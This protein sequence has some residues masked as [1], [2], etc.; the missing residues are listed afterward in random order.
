MCQGQDPSY[1]TPG[2]IWLLVCAST[3]TWGA[4][5]SLQG[6]MR[7]V[8]IASHQMAVD[9]PLS[10]ALRDLGSA[11]PTGP[12]FRLSACPTPVL[13]LTFQALHKVSLAIAVS[14][15][16]GDSPGEA[17]RFIHTSGGLQAW[18]MLW[19]RQD[20]GQ[21]IQSLRA[22]QN[23]EQQLCHICMPC[24]QIQ[25]R[26]SF[27]CPLTRPYKSAG[28]HKTGFKCT[29]WEARDLASTGNT[30]SPYPYHQNGDCNSPPARALG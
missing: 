2:P 22:F 9:T 30:I 1:T 24:T 12:V 26:Y 21:C 13:L 11:W 17:R 27:L 3:P 23:L 20:Y 25:H 5:E 6:S 28:E 4:P 29:Y 18:K 19:T 15:H 8:Y 10:Q 7:C 14:R 16:I